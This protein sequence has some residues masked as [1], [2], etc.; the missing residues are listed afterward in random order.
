MAKTDEEKQIMKKCIDICN[1]NNHDN[2]AKLIEKEYPGCVVS[3]HFDYHHYAGQTMK[4]F[5]GMMMWK[6]FFITF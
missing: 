1:R 5:M 2:S 3:L 6:N 4:Q